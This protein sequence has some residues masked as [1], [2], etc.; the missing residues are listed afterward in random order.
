MRTIDLEQYPG[1][2]LI[3]QGILDSQENRKTI[4][5]CLIQIAFPTLSKMNILPSEIQLLNQ[6]DAELTLYRI[7]KSETGD[8]YSRYNALIRQLISFERAITRKPLVIRR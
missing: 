2:D 4:F 6:E 3:K 5:S 8:A 7:L 1:G